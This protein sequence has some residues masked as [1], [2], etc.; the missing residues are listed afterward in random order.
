VWIICDR[1][2]IAKISGSI[3]MSGLVDE[4]DRCIFGEYPGKLKDVLGIWVEE[5]DAL[6]P[7]EIVCW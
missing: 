2:G 6:R 3:Y 5:V 7:Y 4:N 1:K